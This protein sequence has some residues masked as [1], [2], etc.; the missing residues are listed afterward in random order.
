MSDRTMIWDPAHLAA[1]CDAIQDA[2][3]RGGELPA[4]DPRTGYVADVLIAGRAVM[5]GVFE[6]MPDAEHIVWL[7]D[8]LP[9][10]ALR[11][12]AFERLWSEDRRRAGRDYYDAEP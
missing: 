6:R 4:H 11:L 5:D 8:E 3:R 10:E 12:L 7:I 9:P 2:Y 1:A